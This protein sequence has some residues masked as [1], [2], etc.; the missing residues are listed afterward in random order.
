MYYNICRMIH[1]CVSNSSLY[2]SS[3]MLHQYKANYELHSTVS[4]TFFLQIDTKTSSVNDKSGKFYCKLEANTET[5]RS[6][7]DI[8]LK[9]MSTGFAC[10][11]SHG[12]SSFCFCPLVN[13]MNNTIICG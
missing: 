7:F 3:E 5:S 12:S 4:R 13:Y 6:T 1:Q 2:R 9:T 10:H 8:R 11:K